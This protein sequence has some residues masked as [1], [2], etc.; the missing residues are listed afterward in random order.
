MRTL[1]LDHRPAF[2][3]SP[4]LFPKSCGREASDSLSS[5]IFSRIGG[6]LSSVALMVIR[7]IYRKLVLV[8]R[9]QEPPWGRTYLSL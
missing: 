6:T 2:C 7:Y 9:P 4:H 8:Q 5:I 3:L 1:A